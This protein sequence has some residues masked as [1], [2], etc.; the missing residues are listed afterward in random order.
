MAPKT[1][2]FQQLHPGRLTWNVIIGDWKIIFLSKWVIGMFHVNLAGCNLP[3]ISNSDQ[4]ADVREVNVSSAIP[5]EVEAM[6]SEHQM[7]TM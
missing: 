6:E 2:R 7:A 1:L 5:L 4:G 3:G